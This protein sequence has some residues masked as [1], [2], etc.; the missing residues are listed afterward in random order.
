[1]RTQRNLPTTRTRPRV[2]A[3]ETG[4]RQFGCWQR[5]RALSC[6]ARRVGVGCGVGALCAGMW[7]Q[8]QYQRRE[9]VPS[10]ARRHAPPSSRGAL[11]GASTRGL[12]EEYSS[13]VTCDLHRLFSQGKSFVTY[14]HRAKFLWPILTGQIICVLFSLGKFFVAYSHWANHLWPI[15]TGQNFCGLFSLGNSFVAYSSFFP[16]FG[17]ESAW[18]SAGPS[19]WASAWASA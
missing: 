10:H 13:F 2:A 15:L 4:W 7:D 6:A 1:M 14:S 5:R 16:V 3:A 8:R 19:A 9:R 18:A 12:K 11:R 17:M